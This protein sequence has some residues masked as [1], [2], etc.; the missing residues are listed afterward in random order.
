[1]ETPDLEIVGLLSSTN[2]RSCT[3]HGCCGDHVGVGDVL[4]LVECHVTVKGTVEKAVKCV[5]VVNGIDT[6]T[7]AF[8]PR[9]LMNLPQVQN[10]L[11]GFVQVSEVYADSKNWYKKNKSHTNSGMASV[12]LLDKHVGRDE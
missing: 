3:V 2:G 9:A 4:R 8:V 10:N 7:V 12:E 6:C 1:M 11:N 5:K